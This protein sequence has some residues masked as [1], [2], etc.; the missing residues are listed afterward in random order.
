[1]NGIK[2]YIS[3]RGGCPTVVACRSGGSISIASRG[4]SLA[5][6]SSGVH[7]RFR[8]CG[9]AVRPVLLGTAPRSRQDKHLTDPFSIGIG[10]IRKKEVSAMACDETLYR[11][12]LSGDDAGLEALMKNTAPP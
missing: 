1:M 12:Y 5:S 4:G 10:S 3:I 6:P 7:G 2:G 9:K 11:Q 8:K